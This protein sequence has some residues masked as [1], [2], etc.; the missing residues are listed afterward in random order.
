[1][2]RAEFRQRAIIAAMQG[3]LSSMPAYYGHDYDAKKIAAAAQELA[4]AL[5]EANT[6]DDDV[7]L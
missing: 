7:P 3:M 6:V 5:V 4:D 1:M 2:D